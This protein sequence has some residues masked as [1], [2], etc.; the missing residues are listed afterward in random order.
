MG[1][2]AAG[3]AGCGVRRLSGAADCAVA[4]GEKAEDAGRDV[5]CAVGGLSDC[6]ELGFLRGC[7]GFCGR[8]RDRRSASVAWGK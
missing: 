8:V 3:R 1:D 5:D 2:R 4:G 6:A 7:A